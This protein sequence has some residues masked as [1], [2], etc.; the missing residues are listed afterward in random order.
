[1]VGPRKIRVVPQASVATRLVLVPLQPTPSHATIFAIH[2]NH[3]FTTMSESI[4]MEVLQGSRKFQNGLGSPKQTGSQ[5]IE[6]TVL[7]TRYL[8]K[9]FTHK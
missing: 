9:L 4:L 3:S 1:V 2:P 6:I 8:G 5:N 7:S